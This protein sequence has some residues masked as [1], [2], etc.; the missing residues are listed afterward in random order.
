VAEFHRLPEHPGD[1]RGKNAAPQTSSENLM[2]AISMT[3]TFITA[4]GGEVKTALW[5]QS[6]FDLRRNPE[7]ARGR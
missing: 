6:S 7:L 3:S 2:E 1:C 4:A 5:K